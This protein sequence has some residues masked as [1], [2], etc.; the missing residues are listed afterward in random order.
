MIEISV[1]SQVATAQ[2]ENIIF[3]KLHK[4]EQ[5]VTDLL[6]KDKLILTEKELK[7]KE[8]LVSL[9]KTNLTYVLN[10]L[11]QNEKLFAQ[12]I[13]NKLF[14]GRVIGIQ[15]KAN[16]IEYISVLDFLQ[17]FR[18][19]VSK[20]ELLIGLTIN[21]PVLSISL[22]KNFIDYIKIIEYDNIQEFKITKENGDELNQLYFT[23]GNYIIRQ[24]I[25]ATNDR[26]KKTVLIRK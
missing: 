23:K 20:G 5:K 12:K 22:P 3:N 2:L 18:H 9:I 17:E 14:L 4:I 21:Y 16:V 25:D 1:N 13:D 6:K 24:I 19:G 7:C 8:F 15:K 26:L 11:I 10:I